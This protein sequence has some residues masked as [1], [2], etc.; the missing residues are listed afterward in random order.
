[1]GI[2]VYWEAV[3]CM[4]LHQVKTW[5]LGIE[6]FFP[7]LLN[8][9]SFPFLF[10]L[11]AFP[12][13]ENKMAFY[14]WRT[15]VDSWARY[16]LCKSTSQGGTWRLQSRAR[17]TFFPQSQKWTLSWWLLPVGITA[18]VTQFSR[19]CISMWGSFPWCHSYSCLCG[20]LKGKCSDP[21]SPFV[22]RSLLSE[23]PWLYRC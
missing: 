11:W 13:A 17:D 4:D 3:G 6:S 18:A 14:K 8:F 22:V 23:H 20:L 1:M 15:K 2:L 9:L 16:S 5:C 7:P 21:F 12:L 19:S 10:S